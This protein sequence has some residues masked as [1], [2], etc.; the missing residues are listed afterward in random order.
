MPISID[1]LNKHVLVYTQN[2]F[3]LTRKNANNVGLWGELG[4]KRE[5]RKSSILG[6]LV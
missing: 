5:E 2:S 6:I 1:W 3:R 4:N